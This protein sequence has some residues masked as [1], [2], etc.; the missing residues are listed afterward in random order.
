VGHNTIFDGPITDPALLVEHV[1]RWLEEIRTAL[2]LAPYLRVNPEFW[3]FL[4][5][6][7]QVAKSYPL[8][9]AHYTSDEP[10][11]PEGWKDYAVWQHTG[12]GHVDGVGTRVTMNVTHRAPWA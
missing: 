1:S 8:W 9:L 6:P 4:G 3:R 11:I 12:T 10:L 7:V 5:E 2:G